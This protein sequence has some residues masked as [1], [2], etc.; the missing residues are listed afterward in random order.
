MMTAKLKSISELLLLNVT[1][2]LK[3]PSVSMVH[4]VRLFITFIGPVIKIQSERG[5]E[6]ARERGRER[7]PNSKEIL[8]RCERLGCR[9]KC[10]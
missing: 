8:V 4:R 10:L 6:K 9:A 5:R 1:P 7:M 3:T 2:V